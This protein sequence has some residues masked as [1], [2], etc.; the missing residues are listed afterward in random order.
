MTIAEQAHKKIAQERE[1]L[2]VKA[3]A[4]VDADW[5]RRFAEDAIRTKQERQ[6]HEDHMA[7]TRRA[8]ADKAKKVDRVLDRIVGTS[9][10]DEIEV[11]DLAIADQIRVANL[12]KRGRGRPKGVKNKPKVVTPSA[13]GHIPDDDLVIP[14]G[15]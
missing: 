14:R 13:I 11:G 6:F 10:L 2:L 7:A 5:K 8:E 1:D 3:R 4:E 12:P 15:K 9:S